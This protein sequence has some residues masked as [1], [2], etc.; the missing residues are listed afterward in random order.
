[1]PEMKKLI[2]GEDEFEVVDAAAR[3]SAVTLGAR[4]DEIIALP[5]GS[6]TADAELVDIRIGA[7]GTTYDSAGE[8]VRT[9]IEQAMDAAGGLDLSDL[10]MEAEQ[11]QETGFSILTLSDGTT[12]KSVDIPVASLD[13]TD[14]TLITNIVEDYLNNLVNGDEVNY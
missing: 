14:V 6:T 2:I 1:M 10:T 7:N 9:Q 8:A 5:D 4:I 11:S 3:T 13:P 12:E